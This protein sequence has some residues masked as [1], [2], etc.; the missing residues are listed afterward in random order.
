MV[1]VSLP[2]EHFADIST[3]RTSRAA[4]A[5]QT[6]L[7]FFDSF[8][9]GQHSGKILKVFESLLGLFEAKSH[10]WFPGFVALSFQH[11]CLIDLDK[12]G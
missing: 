3:D 4:A 1:Y 10:P 8:C 6:S 5:G 2:C 11:F 9:L 12:L 7:S